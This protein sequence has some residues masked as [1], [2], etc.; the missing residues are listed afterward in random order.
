RSLG[1][2]T[3]S[4]LTEDKHPYPR[5]CLKE[6]LDRAIEK[7]EPEFIV[8][9]YGMNDGIYHPLNEERMQAFQEGVF[10][11]AT[12][13]KAAKAPLLIITPP[14]FDSLAASAKLADEGAPE[15]GYAHPYRGYDL[16]LGA[17]GDWQV[18]EAGRQWQVVDLHRDFK[19]QLMERRKTQADF[20]YAADGVH[21]TPE[22][23]LL[24]ARIIARQSGM[25][26]DAV[27][28]QDAETIFNDPLFKL[29]DQRRRARSEAWLPYVGY[30]RGK[31]VASN[32][33]KDLEATIQRL[34]KEIKALQ[35]V[36]Q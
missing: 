29:V 21:P 15:F 18:E 4:C 7:I 17:F 6:R 35:S 34:D 12:T 3:L 32:S 33:L 16:V 8:A 19:A 13:S 2:E 10:H 22:G 20:S 9:C 1:S 31:V 24:I 30:T 11:L 27:L 36:T 23:H 26:V 28:G 25:Q 5:P 14:P